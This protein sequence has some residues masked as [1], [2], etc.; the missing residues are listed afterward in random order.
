MREAFESKK[1]LFFSDCS[2]LQTIEEHTNSAKDL[3]N[4]ALAKL[5]EAYAKVLENENVKNI[6]GKIQE[7]MDKLVAK[8]KEIAGM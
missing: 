6:E 1:T 7:V 8:A 4:Q 3:F 2:P 5:K